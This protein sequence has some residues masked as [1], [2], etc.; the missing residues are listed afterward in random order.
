MLPSS[1]SSLQLLLL[2]R[3]FLFISLANDRHAMGNAPWTTRDVPTSNGRLEGKGPGIRDRTRQQ[4]RRGRI[5]DTAAADTAAAAAAAVDAAETA[6]A[7]ARAAADTAETA[8]AR[9]AG[10]GGAG[11]ATEKVS[12]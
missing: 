3:P 12:P 2:L 8:A 5:R 1:L 6:A 7:A 11:E 9:A 4:R 10:R